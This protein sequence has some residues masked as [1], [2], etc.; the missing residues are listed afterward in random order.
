MVSATDGKKRRAL[1]NSKVESVQ[2]RFT[3]KLPGL[4]NVPYLERIR[5][6]I[7][8]RLDVRRL[9]FDIL[10]VYKMLFGLVWLDFRMFF[11]LGPVDN[12]RGRCYKLLIPSSNTDIRK[13]FFSVRIV[14]VWNELPASTDFSTLRRFSNSIHK[15]DLARY[16]NEL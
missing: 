16:C 6:L 7:L 2:R 10:C 9:R 3:K 13:Y 5:K 12:T 14:K 15:L 11:T 1:R 4:Y 8:E